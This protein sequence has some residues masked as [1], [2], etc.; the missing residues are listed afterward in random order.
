MRTV[1]YD[2][3]TGVKNDFYTLWR[4]TTVDLR[5]RDDDGKILSNYKV[6]S[7]G[8]NM[9]YHIYFTFCQNL[10]KT[11]EAALSKLNELNIELSPDV[12]DFDLKHYSKPSFEAF[13]TKM[14]F[15]KDKWCAPANSDFFKAWKENKIEMK[16]M[17]WSCWNYKNQWY[18]AIKLES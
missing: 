7:L 13:G 11:K 18:M 2:I 14:K 15:K 10:G 1:E 6:N 12:F 16:R 8:G 5:P 17:G 3:G 9:Y 4:T